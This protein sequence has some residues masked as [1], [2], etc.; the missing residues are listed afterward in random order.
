MASP[1]LKVQD[2]N[3]YTKQNETKSGWLINPTL[4]GRVSE[5]LLDGQPYP[6]GAGF[7]FIHQ[8]E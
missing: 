7:E 6:E 5:G 3:L 8:T 4:K 2:L 1:I